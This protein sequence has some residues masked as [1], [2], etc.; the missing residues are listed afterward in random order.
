MKNCWNIGIRMKVVKSL[1]QDKHLH[2]RTDNVMY[3][4]LKTERLFIRPLC[5]KDLETTYRY[6]GDK[7]LTRYMMFLPDE[8]IEATK[9]FIKGIEE[10][11]QGD[12]QR[13]F[14]FVIFKEDEHIG[15]ISVYLENDNNETVGELGWIIKKEY[16]GKG[17][18]T[19]AA[20]VLM[21]FSFHKL[22]LRK[23]IAHC[24]ARNK[25]SA[26]VMQKIGMTL[27]CEGARQYQKTGEIAGEY[28]YS[29]VKGQM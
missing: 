26:R 10:E 3:T 18:V 27:E 17:Y 9:E 15:G 8:S 19:E 4:E 29:I 22:G 13:R 1:Q 25:A 21:E 23:L 11:Q 7:E 16:W 28:K 14:E 24:D 20:K 2:R 12:S 6:Q 5:M